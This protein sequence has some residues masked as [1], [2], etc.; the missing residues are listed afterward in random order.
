[1]TIT[2]KGRRALDYI[3]QCQIDW[4]NRVSETLSLEEL[5]TAVT[6]LRQLEERLESHETD[7]LDE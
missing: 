4:A 7:E 6:V 5:E 3:Q 1:M 2:P